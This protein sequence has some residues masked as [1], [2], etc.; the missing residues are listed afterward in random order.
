[1]TFMLSV[2]RLSRDRYP[3]RQNGER[4]PCNLCGGEDRVVVR[5]R[6]RYLNRLVN[7]MCRHCGLVFLDPMPNDAD[8]DTYYRHFFWSASQGGDEPPAKRILRDTRN[9]HWRLDRITPVVKPGARILDVG[10]GS[11]AFLGQAK[12]AGFAVEGIEPNIGYARYTERT[13][14]V[15]VHTAPLNDVDFGDRKFDLITCSHALEHMRDPFGALRRFHTL[16]EPDGHIDIAVPDLGEANSSPLRHLHSGHLFGFTHETLIMMAAKAGF[17]TID[18]SRHCTLHLC[19]R[20]PG[21]DPHWFRFPGHV[22][23]SEAMFRERTVL[24]YLLTANSFV[25][26]PS[27]I[28]RWLSDIRGANASARSGRP[29][30]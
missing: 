13:F 26:I 18:E 24:H 2:L 22:A 23:A 29:S 27:R 3:L 17:E 6:D 30:A 11:G 12:K 1:M 19:R 20:L 5:T 21:P 8:I 14:G 7:V 9:A 28:A 25:R 15:K 10:S 16:L 4:Q